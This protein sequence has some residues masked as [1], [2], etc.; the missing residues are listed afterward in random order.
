MKFS[1]FACAVEGHLGEVP[2]RDLP[3]TGRAWEDMG[4]EGKSPVGKPPA[5][6]PR[7]ALC[8]RTSSASCQ[9]HRRHPFN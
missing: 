6:H 4:R 8:G 9:E 7:R 3:S 2:L 5:E 1:S